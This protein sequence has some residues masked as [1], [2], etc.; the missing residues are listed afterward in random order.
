[1]A[2]EA[3]GLLNAASQVD[4]RTT[5]TQHHHNKEE[6][7]KGKWQ[8]RTE[9]TA[10][11]GF[12]FPGFV[13]SFHRRYCYFHGTFFLLYITVKI[14]CRAFIQI[15]LWSPFRILYGDGWAIRDQ[16]K[17]K[18]HKRLNGETGRVCFIES[19]L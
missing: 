3:I 10:L 6:T 19:I 1:L 9:L 14:R 2:L 12:F 13:S 4:R 7:N 17:T 15:F 11:K 5:I 18:Y 16:N 8:E